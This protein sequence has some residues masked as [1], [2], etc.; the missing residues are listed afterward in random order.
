M[1]EDPT[2]LDAKLLFASM[3]EREERYAILD[4]ARRVGRT[5]LI[6]K[7]GPKTFEDSGDYVGHFWGI[8]ETRPVRCLFYSSLF[9]LDILYFD[10]PLPCLWQKYMR[11]GSTSASSGALLCLQMIILFIECYAVCRKITLWIRS[12]RRQLM[13]LVSDI[14]STPLSSHSRGSLLVEMLRLCPGDN[15][16]Q[17]ISSSLDWIRTIFFL[18]YSRCVTQLPHTFTAISGGSQFCLQL[19]GVHRWLVATSRRWYNHSAPKKWLR[20]CP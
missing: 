12:G 8:I 4:A 18:R 20:L 14:D 10:S 5:T 3:H 2:N 17:Y 15:M 7:F 11:W 16:G 13:S 6:Q 1:K 9:P 19:D